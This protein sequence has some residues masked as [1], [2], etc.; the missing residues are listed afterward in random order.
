MHALLFTQIGILM[1]ER[2]SMQLIDGVRIV[3]MV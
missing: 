2:S 1:H 3:V